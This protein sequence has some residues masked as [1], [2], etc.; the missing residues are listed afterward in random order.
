MPTYQVGDAES[1]DPRPL[2]PH[3]PLTCVPCGAV[4]G[5]VSA[6]HAHASM[7][8]ASVCGVFPEARPAVE[9]HERDCPARRLGGA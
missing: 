2:V 1:A 9:R 3:R 4:L 6:V 8:A 7:T 5:S